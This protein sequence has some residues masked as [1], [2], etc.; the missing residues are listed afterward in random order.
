MMSRSAWLQ[1]R[2]AR[3]TSVPYGL[4]QPRPPRASGVVGC[5]VASPRHVAVMWEWFG[6][7]VVLAGSL[8]STSFVAVFLES[9]TP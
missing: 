2:A 5:T 3:E 7:V 9:A 8:E 4:L 6:V 1:C